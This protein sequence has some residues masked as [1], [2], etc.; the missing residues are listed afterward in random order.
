MDAWLE[1]E[2]AVGVPG[3]GDVSEVCYE[4]GGVRGCTSRDLGDSR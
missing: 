3:V 2:G 1:V 4:R